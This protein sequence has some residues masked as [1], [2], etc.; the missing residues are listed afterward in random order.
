M[1]RLKR[2]KGI[3]Y[4][5]IYI[6]RCVNMEIE[7]NK[8][9]ISWMEKWKL[10]DKKHLLRKNTIVWQESNLYLYIYLYD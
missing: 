3:K 8:T 5:Y 1:A 4:P 6:S 2:G 7:I 9:T 10:K